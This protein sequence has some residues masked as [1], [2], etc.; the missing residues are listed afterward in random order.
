MLGLGT[1]KKQPGP[2][3]FFHGERGA[4]TGANVPE[5]DFRQALFHLP[6]I[7]LLD[8]LDVQFHHGHDGLHD[9]GGPCLVLAGHDLADDRGDDLPG[10]AVFVRE[11]AAL[12]FLPA[13]GELF[14]EG[15][16]LF[17]GLAGHH[18]GDGLVEWGSGA[19]VEGQE[20]LP[21]DPKPHGH[22]R[23]LGLVHPRPV[24]GDVQDLGLLENTAIKARGFLCFSIKQQA[25]R[26]FRHGHTPLEIKGYSSMRKVTKAIAEKEQILV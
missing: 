1:L 24:M 15:V 3:I 14:P 9:P 2:D 25:G 19:A 16:D 6:G 23:S 5:T 17:L 13:V 26:H 11:P 4:F 10:K 20:F 12:D 7:G 22:D 8:R 21:V 18:D